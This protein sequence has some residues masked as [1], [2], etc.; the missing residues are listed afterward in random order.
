M[1]YNPFVGVGTS[2]PTWT[3]LNG[4]W[5][6]NFYPYRLDVDCMPAFSYREDMFGEIKHTMQQNPTDY[7]VYREEWL[8]HVWTAEDRSSVHCFY[9]DRPSQII[10]F[11]EQHLHHYKKWEIALTPYIRGPMDEILD[12][13]TLEEFTVEYPYSVEISME[14]DGID[15]EDWLI[16]NGMAHVDDW[17][18]IK[19]RH[20]GIYTL[21]FRDAS[22]AVLAKLRWS[23]VGF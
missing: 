9:F 20:N 12:V 14:H 7:G 6:E 5:F 21:Y 18:C 22:K 19:M 11:R 15:I 17:K 13:N 10:A 3:P 4:S 8:G 23:G 1:T 16:E 2:P